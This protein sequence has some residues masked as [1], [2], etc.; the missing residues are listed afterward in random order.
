MRLGMIFG[1]F[2]YSVFGLLD[3]YM[4]PSNYM[5]AWII[6]YVVAVP[7]II[8]LF[9]LS[10]NKKFYQYQRVILLTL[11]FFGQLGIVAM[12]YISK[13]NDPAFYAYYAG[14]ILVVLWASFIFRLKFKVAFYFT[15]L[16]VV[17]YNLTAIFKQQLIFNTGNPNYLVWFL[18]N[19]FFLISSAILATVGAY[20]LEKHE[21]ELDAIYA[22]LIS[23]KKEL[24]KAKE[25]AEESN[26]LKTEFLNNMSHEIR[27]PLNGI[28]GF[29]TFLNNPD[30]TTE[31]KA[32]FINIIQKSSHNLLNIVEDILEIS[33]LSTGQIKIYEQ[34]TFLNNEFQE[35]YST[36][37]PIATEK[38]LTLS[39]KADLPDKAFYIFTDKTKLNKILS[40]L[41]D[42]A[43]KYTSEG[44]VELGCELLKDGR[45]VRF[46]VK[47]TGIGIAENKHKI[48]FER[49]S[50]EEREISQKAGGLGLGLSIASELVT[51]LKGEISVKSEKGKGT[52]FFVQIPFKK[53]PS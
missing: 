25:K 17:L 45:L 16:T 33:E 46:Y 29:S 51:L 34:K 36:Y 26:Q 42:N 2:I 6:R 39:L 47:D 37:N 3:L 49:F 30:L 20:R 38:G 8:I 23:D 28:L 43:L 15:V 4:M 13:P 31:K 18:G 14:L 9:I 35:L 11:L 21:N 22:E 50:Q 27:T 19:N 1:V 32:Q 40:I 44:K 48:I 41:L 24:E 52:T 12:I 53:L 7:A 5:S 10:Y